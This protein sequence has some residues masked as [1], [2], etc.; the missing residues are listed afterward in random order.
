MDCMHVSLESSVQP[1][2]DALLP[3]RDPLAQTGRDVEFG[4]FNDIANC[5]FKPAIRPSSQ[6][7]SPRSWSSMSTGDSLRK[8]KSIERIRQRQEELL[9]ASHTFKPVLY[10][11]P[12][13]L[14]STP[15]RLMARDPSFTARVNQKNEARTS[16]AL[17]AQYEREVTTI[18]ARCEPRVLCAHGGARYPCHAQHCLMRKFGYCLQNDHTADIQRVHAGD[19]DERVYIQTNHRKDAQTYPTVNA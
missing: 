13:N 18:C 10:T 12:G 8:H 19:R 2:D 16:K 7:R 1:Y 14:A 15:G 6:A 9:N 4:T 5:T 11:P 3:L 17:R